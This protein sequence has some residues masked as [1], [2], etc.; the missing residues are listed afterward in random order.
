[1]GKTSLGKSIARALGRKFVRMSLGGVH[2]EAEIR[3]HRRTYIGAMPGRIIQASPRG[4]RD[5]VFMLDEIDKVGADWHGDPSSALL[6]VLDPA[7]NHASWTT[8][9]REL[10]PLAVLFI[11]TANTRHDPGAAARSMEV[12]QLPATPTRRRSHRGAATW[13]RSRW[14]HTACRPGELSHRA[15]G[16]ARIV[17]E[18]TR[19][20]GVRNLE[21]EIA[22][23]AARS[24][25][26]SPRRR[27]APVRVT[28]EDRP[29]YL[30]RAVLRRGGGAD[31]AARRG[32]GPGLDPGRR[33]RALRRGHA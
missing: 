9:W 30:G 32:D 21:R 24:R 11:A 20:A 12:S 6:E 3:G 15:G 4:S 29:E 13:C 26:G 22:T 28:A 8:T 33:R 14:R 27:A 16:H 31:D 2:D 5:P 17:R 18:Y 19:E 1:V 25:A 7:Q 23:V 10:R